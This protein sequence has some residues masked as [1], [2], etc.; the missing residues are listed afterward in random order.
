MKQFFQTQ[1]ESSSPLSRTCDHMWRASVRSEKKCAC[2]RDGEVLSVHPPSRSW[3]LPLSGRETA[4]K[5]EEIWEMRK[6][7]NGVRIQ[8]NLTTI[9]TFP[10]WPLRTSLLVLVCA[11][12]WRCR[13]CRWSHH[14][15]SCHPWECHSCHSMV[16]RWRTPPRWA[17]CPC[18]GWRWR[19]IRLPVETQPF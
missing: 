4:T 19:E 11:W 8:V 16:P 14:S 7:T 17:F 15:L 2:V 3:Q 1:T 18:W 10:L 12:L 6:T 5:E 9:E 13:C